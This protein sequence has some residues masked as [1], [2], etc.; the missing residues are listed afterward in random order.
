[1]IIEMKH[2][3]HVDELQFKARGV[4]VWE[5][6]ELVSQGNALV[7]EAFEIMEQEDMLSATIAF[8]TKNLDTL[9]GTV[10]NY[11]DLSEEQVNNLEVRTLIHIINELLNVNGISIKKVWSFFQKALKEQATNKILEPQM[12][13]QTVNQ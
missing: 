12:G 2:N 7:H 8:A 10:V 11:T 9:V 4:K 13:Y 6:K 1:M 3:I 5:I